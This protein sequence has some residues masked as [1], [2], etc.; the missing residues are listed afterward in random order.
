MWI[1]FHLHSIHSDG[2]C[3]PLE[4]FDLAVDAKIE[5]L[6]LTDHDNV[7]GLE[8]CRQL[9]KKKGIGFVNGVEVSAAAPKGELHLLGYGFDPSHSAIRSLLSS[10]VEQRNER[11]LRIVGRLNELGVAI[12]MEEIVA[13]ATGNTVGRPHFAAALLDKKAVRN[14]RE[15]F[16][17]Y[18]GQGGRAYVEQSRTE[19][20][21]V[22]DAFH[23]AGG[24][25]FVAHPVSL[26]LEGDELVD[27]LKKLRGIGM[28]GIE[29]YNSSVKPKLSG[30][31]LELAR[32]FG[33]LVS[34]GSDFH[35]ANKSHVQLGHVSQNR[36][37]SSDDVSFSFFE[38][39]FV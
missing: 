10:C 24:K 25:T 15:A 8:K 28:D 6:A 22:V 21:V 1:D 20:R 2:T 36:R 3:D 7:D 23:E 38:S 34:G 4:I 13:K 27:Y 9:A 16:D 18:L 17:V 19:A 35:G 14:Y 12:E 32:R 5:A 29:V 33:F 30:E 26:K 39:R 37:L 11:N 31:L